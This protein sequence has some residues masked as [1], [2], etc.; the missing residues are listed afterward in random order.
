MSSLIKGIWMFIPYLFYLQFSS[1]SHT[2]NTSNAGIYVTLSEVSMV[3]VVYTFKH[4]ICRTDHEYNAPMG[5]G[6]CLP[7]KVCLCV[8]E[9]LF[10]VR[11]QTFWMVALVIWSVPTGSVRSL[12]WDPSVLSLLLVLSA[13]LLVFA[14]SE[15]CP[16]WC[17]WLWAKL[18]YIQNVLTNLH[19]PKYGWETLK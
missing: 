3:N 18:M 10:S 9:K 12:I 6:P 4:L 11:L 15:G 8:P 2:T 1:Y 17:K 7:P 5:S 16:W 19:C 13:K 14:L